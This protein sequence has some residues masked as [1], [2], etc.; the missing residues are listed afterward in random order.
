MVR[1]SGLCPGAEH[2]RGPHFASVSPLR[3]R[4]SI[5]A[6]VRQ[7]AEHQRSIRI[8]LGG[9][10]AIVPLASGFTAIHCEPP[11]QTFVTM[12]SFSERTD[13]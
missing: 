1:Y 2:L 7:Q 6:T 11:G 9:E 8:A 3:A 12:S 5:G 10:A 13:L 4:P